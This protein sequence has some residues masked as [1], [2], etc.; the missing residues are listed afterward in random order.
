MGSSAQVADG[1]QYANME[2]KQKGDG[3]V[4]ALWQIDRHG[5]VPLSSSS[6]LVQGLETKELSTQLFFG[7]FGTDEH[8]AFE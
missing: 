2:R 4:M 6:C 8:K 5:A 7:T 3:H 1:F